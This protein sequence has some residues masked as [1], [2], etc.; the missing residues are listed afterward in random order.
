M[1]VS[2][3]KVELGQG[4]LTALSQVAAEELDVGPERIRIV[5]G[6]TQD[7]PNEVYT[8]G[9]LSVSNSGSA[10]RLVCAEVRWLFLEHAA[11]LLSCEPDLLSISDGRVLVDGRATDHNYWTM[12][13]G[14][15]LA[16]SWSGLA[17][18][19]DPAAFRVIGRDMPR[20]DLPAKISGGA[21]IHDFAPGKL[22]HARV[23]HQPWRDALLVEFD[24][25]VLR[26]KV[27]SKIEVFREGN[28]LALLSDDE[29]AVESA[30]SI[31]EPLCVWKGGSKVPDNAGEV[32]WLKGQRADIRVI[33][34]SHALDDGY[35]GIAQ[36]SIQPPLSGSWVDRAFLCAC[37]V[38]RGAVVGM[39]TLARRL[40]F[41]D[42]PGPPYCSSTRNGSMLNIGK[43]PAAMVTMVRMMR[44]STLP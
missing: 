44:H 20:L 28:F 2:T 36:G 5:S 43:G 11:R 7:G 39:D 33:S 32:E 26:R 18:V 9:S 23:I 4:I 24:E 25:D 41:A 15:D 13:G 40:P 17:Q 8:S 16:R 19:K 29:A 14:V 6:K 22:V 35:R 30:M 12:S 42:G 10:L 34:S 31:V 37:N 1:R 38:R 21:F 3:G 27:R